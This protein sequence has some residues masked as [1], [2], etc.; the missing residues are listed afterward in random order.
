ML[1]FYP[2]YYEKL[3]RR[4]PN[5]DIVLL[6]YETRMFKSNAQAKKHD[7]FKDEE[8][9]RAQ[10]VKR[11]KDEV[12]KGSNT[13]GLREAKRAWGK[14]ERYSGLPLQLYQMILEMID[15]GDAKGRTYRGFLVNLHGAFMKMYGQSDGKQTKGD[16]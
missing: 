5:I 9:L 8:S 6:Y 13:N 16:T 3:Q 15:G 11:I 4:C 1:V 10:I 7:Q 14:I 2:N 12:R